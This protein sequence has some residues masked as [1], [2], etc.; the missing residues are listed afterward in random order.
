M[1]NQ[2]LIKEL[3]KIVGEENVL[4]SH[5]DLMLYSYDASLEKGKPDV[6]VLPSSTEEVSKVMA[7]SPVSA[8]IS[9]SITA[10]EGVLS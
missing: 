6:V 1:D 7:L 4:H 3:E 2:E 10:P 9:L 5:M 8:S